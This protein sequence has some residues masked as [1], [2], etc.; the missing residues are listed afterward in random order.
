MRANPFGSTTTCVAYECTS[1]PRRKK[2]DLRRKTTVLN[3]LIRAAP[4]SQRPLVLF[5]AIAQSAPALQKYA[6]G[7]DADFLNKGILSTSVTYAGA[8]DFLDEGDTCCMLVL[9]VPK[10]TRMLEVL[11]NSVWAEEGEVL[12]PHGSNFK[13]VHTAVIDE[14]TT[15]YCVLVSQKARA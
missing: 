9:L 12:L 1:F 14:I 5:R 7:T 3:K 13:V 2:S 4:V 15:Y 8:R 11:D 6:R 10:G